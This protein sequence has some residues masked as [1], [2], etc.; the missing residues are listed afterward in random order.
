MAESPTV[1]TRIAQPYV[2]IPVKVRMEDL[3]SV[4]RPLTDQVFD[5]LGTRGITPVGPPFWR[6][7][8]PAA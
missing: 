5:W 3:A 4:V 2:A 1:E 7:G 8:V 6:Y